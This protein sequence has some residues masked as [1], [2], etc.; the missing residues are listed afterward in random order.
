MFRTP[1]IQ[2]EDISSGP[3]VDLGLPSGTL[4][5]SCNIGANAHEEYGDYFAWGETET[6]SNYDWSTYKYAKGA[7]DKLTKYC[8]NSDYGYNDY[9]DSRTTLER[10]DDAAS[11]NWGSDWCMPT[12]E[13]FQELRD[14]CKWT[15]VSLNGKNGYKVEGQNGNTIF[16]P[17]AGCRYG[18]SLYYDGSYGLY[19]SSSLDSDYPYS[20]RN[21]YF[22]SGGVNP[23]YW[24][25]RFSGFSVRP[26]RCR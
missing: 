21:L 14:K 15:W 17:A 7:D 11:A 1:V 23:D 2:S 9:T 25:Y 6:K 26:V 22:Y 5:A 8:N 10:S 4:W 20:G 12:A 18:T 24:Y 16:L 3:Y 13:Q 19:W